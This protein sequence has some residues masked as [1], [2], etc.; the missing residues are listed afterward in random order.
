MPSI[1]A[2]AALPVVQVGISTSIAAVG[3]VPLSR[4]VEALVTVR[5]THGANARVSQGSSPSKHLSM[6]DL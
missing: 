5:L 2:C 4:L 6:L 3:A 1:L